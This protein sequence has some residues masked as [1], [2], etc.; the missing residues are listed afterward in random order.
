MLP[1]CEADPLPVPDQ[2]GVVVAVEVTLAEWD[3]VTLVVADGDALSDGDE[4]DAT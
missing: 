3:C 2:E 4:D 1:V